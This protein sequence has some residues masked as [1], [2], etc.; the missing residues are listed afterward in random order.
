MTCR[1]EVLAAARTIVGRKG[2][3]EFSPQEVIE[4]MRGT[5]TRYKVSGIR[6][7]VVSR[8]CRNAPWHHATKY[9][10]FERVAYATYRIV[11]RSVGSP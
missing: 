4:H 7:H 10:D 8:M 11:G 5:G 9:E 2:V 6:T 1:D 3:N